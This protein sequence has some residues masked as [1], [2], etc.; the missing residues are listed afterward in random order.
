MSNFIPKK[1]INVDDREPKWMNN[2]TKTKTRSSLR[3]KRLSAE[4]PTIS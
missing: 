2:D 4:A 3:L 1:I